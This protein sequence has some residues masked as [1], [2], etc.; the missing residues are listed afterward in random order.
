MTNIISELQESNKKL[1]EENENLK[2]QLADKE[3]NLRLKIWHVT[4]QSL[5]DK[6]EVSM[7]APR[8]TWWYKNLNKKWTD[9]G[10]LRMAI[11]PQETREWAKNCKRIYFDNITIEEMLEGF[12]DYSNELG[13]SYAG[14]FSRISNLNSQLIQ[15]KRDYEEELKSQAEEIQQLEEAL[16]LEEETSDCHL[17][18]L[19]VA[20]Q[21]RIRQSKEKDDNLERASRKIEMLENI[22]AWQKYLSGKQLQELPSLPK[23]EGKLKL[24][25]NKVKNKVSQV[26]AITQEK[27]ETYILQKNK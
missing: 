2:K 15:Q 13:G 3:E 24:L 21:W 19:E 14:S 7:Y 4:G 8:G 18:A 1:I 23:K 9:E 11:D 20:K 25:T 5:N 6:G 26:K 27:F 17:E 16:E 10:K 12:I 22:V